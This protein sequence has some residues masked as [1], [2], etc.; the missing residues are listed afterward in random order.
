MN[1]P[2]SPTWP[3]AS[4][5]LLGVDA[6]PDELDFGVANNRVVAR[7]RRTY[8]L[9]HGST[10][11]SG[12]RSAPSGCPP[13]TGASCPL[14][15][16][17]RYPAETARRWRLPRP[18]HTA[19]NHDK[20]V[21]GL[22]RRCHSHRQAP[23]SI[24]HDRGLESSQRPHARLPRAQT[25]TPARC[26]ARGEA[27][28]QAVRVRRRSDAGHRGGSCRA[29]NVLTG[30]PRQDQTGCPGINSRVVSSA[31]RT[32]FIGMWDSSIGYR[33]S[34]TAGSPGRLAVWRPLR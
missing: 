29:V 13:G 19:E 3:V 9:R 15:D 27:V 24:G 21:T 31:V 25:K 11:V 23:G 20:C 8:H 33:K 16:G 22:Q 34:G 7:P 1:A 30:H 26:L 32:G 10:R 6:C 12:S 18:F 17:R 14:G 5:R 28:L 2:A 4:N